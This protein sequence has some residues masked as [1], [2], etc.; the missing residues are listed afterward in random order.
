MEGQQ[1]GLAGN[2]LA[3]KPDCLNSSPR[4]C[5]WSLE[6]RSQDKSYRFRSQF[7]STVTVLGSLLFLAWATMGVML[8]MMDN[9]Q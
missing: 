9:L 1:N 5:L 2:T 6:D 8:Y 4:T 7:S 3:L